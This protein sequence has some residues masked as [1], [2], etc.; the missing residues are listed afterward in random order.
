LAN[1]NVLKQGSYFQMK[2][3]GAIRRI[4][5]KNSDVFE[6]ITGS[7]AF[8]LNAKLIPAQN[9][10]A[11][12][13]EPSIKL[14]SSQ[15]R[16]DPYN[17]LDMQKLPEIM[18][19]TRVTPATRQNMPEGILIDF[20]HKNMVHFRMDHQFNYESRAPIGC[21]DNKDFGYLNADF[22][23]EKDWA[24]MRSLNNSIRMTTLAY[25]FSPMDFPLFS[26][27]LAVTKDVVGADPVKG[28]TGKDDSPFQL[29]LTIR[30]GKANGDR[31]LVDPKADKV[32]LFGYYYAGPVAN[33]TRPQGAIFENWYSNKN[34][35]VATLPEAKQLLL[36]AP[37]S[38]GKAQ[39]YS[40]N[41]LED[42]RKAFPD[43]RVE[44][45]EIVAMTIQHDS[46]DTKTSSEAYFKNLSF[47]PLTRTQQQSSK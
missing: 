31:T 15:L 13:Y 29:W 20:H 46:N 5:W 41:L 8:E 27:K 2:E 28:K 36:N 44:D 1:Q 7:T 11:D 18:A 26:M 24:L 16:Y 14:P 9:D 33:E 30:D 17:V 3:P 32:F 23:G 39:V 12:N 19:Q 45:M 35:V 4:S 6:I 38:L 37:D 43:R 22:N 47:S 10:P 21:D 42:L 25:R 40:R 34:V